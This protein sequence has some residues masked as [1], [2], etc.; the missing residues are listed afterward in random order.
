MSNIKSKRI[1][2]KEYLDAFNIVTMYYAQITEESNKL[3]KIAKESIKKSQKAHL[4]P[5]EVGHYYEHWFAI[6]PEMSFRL[7]NILKDNFDGIRFCDI[8]KKQF[9]SC[10]NAG[11]TSWKEFC[12]IFN[13]NEH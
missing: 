1:S 5:N 10:R 3:S 7:I 6:F 9:L 12:S 8:N 2:E 13:A 11:K 4:T